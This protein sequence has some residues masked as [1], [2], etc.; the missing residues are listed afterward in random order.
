MPAG[1]RCGHDYVNYRRRHKTASKRTM[2]FAAWGYST[3]PYTWTHA[4]PPMAEFSWSH[5]R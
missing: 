5:R 1:K 2:A 4:W 3:V